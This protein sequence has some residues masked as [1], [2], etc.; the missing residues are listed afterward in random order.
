M[1]THVANLDEQYDLSQLKETDLDPDPFKQFQKWFEDALKVDLNYPNAMTLATA[2]KNNRPSARMMLLKGADEKG[3]VFYT[4]SESNK[5][6]DLAQNPR[7]AMVL[8]WAKLE[9]QIRIEGKIEQVSEQEADSYFR[10]RPRGSQIGAWV[11][12]QSRVISS[13]KVLDSRMEQ[14]EEEYRNR[15]ITRPPYWLGYRLIPVSIEFWQGRPNRLHDRLRYRLVEDGRW[16][17]ER[18]AP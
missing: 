2:D 5:G 1:D 17:I 3:F 15:E 11:S 10:T 12:E 9:R 13:R 18:L 6:E 4:N 8:W 14:L 16:T 7:A